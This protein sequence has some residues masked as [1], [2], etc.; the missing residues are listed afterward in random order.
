MVL[1][2]PVIHIIK[3]IENRQDWNIKKSKE[4]VENL[5]LNQTS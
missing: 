1:K 5:I 2:I 4:S 3:N